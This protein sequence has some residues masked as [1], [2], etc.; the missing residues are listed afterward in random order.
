M[1]AVGFERSDV[2]FLVLEA[3]LKEELEKWIVLPRSLVLAM[4]FGHFERRAV[5][6]AQEV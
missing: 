1:P 6:T 5:P 3:A 4:C 2:G